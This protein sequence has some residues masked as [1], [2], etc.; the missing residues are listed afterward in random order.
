MKSDVLTLYQDSPLWVRLHTRVRWNMCPFLK[1]AKWVPRRGRIL[2]LGCGHGLMANFL[3]LESAGREV[4]GTDISREKIASARKTIGERK[5]IGFE[6]RGIQDSSNFKKSWRCIL[7]LDVLYLLPLEKWKPVI[8]Q[9]YHAL[10]KG[11]ILLLKEQG[12]RPRLKYLLNLFQEFLA[13][14]ILH[15]TEGAVL[16][17]PGQDAIENLLRKTGFSVKVKHIHKGFSH[18]HILFICQRQ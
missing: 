14:C 11:G 7:I 13:V 2:E 15:L 1:I 18:P 5:N 3:S 17:F 9:C 16:T 8:T 6:R 4:L 12:T 10:E